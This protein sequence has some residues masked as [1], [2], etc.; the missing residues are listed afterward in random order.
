MSRFF[1][2]YNED[3]HFNVYEFSGNQEFNHGAIMDSK[4]EE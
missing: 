1:M 2:L 4:N 3:A